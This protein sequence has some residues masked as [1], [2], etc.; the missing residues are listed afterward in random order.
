VSRFSVGRCTKEVPRRV[1][2]EEGN[3]YRIGKEPNTLEPNSIGGGAPVEEPKGE[4]HLRE[5]RVTG[6][7]RNIPANGKRQNGTA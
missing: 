3:C 1:R 4:L 7:I 5:A 6:K 2:G